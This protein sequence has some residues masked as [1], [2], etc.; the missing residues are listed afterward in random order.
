MKWK[1]DLRVCDEGSPRVVDRSFTVESKS[2]SMALEK[3]LQQARLV[4][5]QTLAVCGCNPLN[6]RAAPRLF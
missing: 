6:D 3:A 5:L 4:G 2:V 1:V